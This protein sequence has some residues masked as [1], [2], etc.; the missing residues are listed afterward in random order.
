MK[1]YRIANK[2]RFI[3]FV[4]TVCLI[5][6]FAVMGIVNTSAAKEKRDLRFTEVTVTEGDT[7]WALAKEYGSKDKDIREVIYDICTV[8]DIKA[9]DLKPGQTV[10]IPGE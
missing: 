9:S 2:A 4:L 5:L 10:L 7:L 8:N 1:H 3:C 6:C